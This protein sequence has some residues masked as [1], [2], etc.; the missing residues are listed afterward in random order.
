MNQLEV[1]Q[2]ENII[3]PIKSKVINEID[4]DPLLLIQLIELKFLHFILAKKLLHLLL[5]ISPII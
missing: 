4:M 2:L 1:I 3:D 5:A